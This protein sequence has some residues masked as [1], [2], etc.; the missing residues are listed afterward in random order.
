[1]PHN[2]FRVALDGAR[3]KLHAELDAQLGLLGTR[4]EEALERAVLDRSAEAPTAVVAAD[5]LPAVSALSHLLDAF[6]DL[7]RL[8]RLSDILTAVVRNATIVAPRAALFVVNGAMLEEWPLQG[9]P[10]LAGGAIALDGAGVL[11]DALRNNRTIG[12]G[13]PHEPPAPPMALLP[14]GRSAIAV[15]VAPGNEPVAVLYADED[16]A[17]VPVDGWRDMV[18]ILVRHAAARLA[19]VTTIRTAEALRLV[20]E[21]A[22]PAVGNDPSGFDEQAVRRYARLVVSE[23]KLYNEAAVRAGREQKDLRS[24]LAVDIDRARQ[25]YEEHVSSAVPNRGAYFEQELVQTLAG[26]DPALLG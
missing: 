16:L 4:Y 26:G 6:S 25:L 20:A 23:I 17:G 8:T 15:P 14:P 7:D 24:R 19:Y 3:A 5:L 11:A 12:A 9:I 18:E 2:Y 1:M 22:Q 10:S 13:G 21:H